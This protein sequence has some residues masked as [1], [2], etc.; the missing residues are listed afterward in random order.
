MVQPPLIG[1]SFF[2]L[3][4]TQFVERFAGFR[5]Q[6]SKKVL[7]LQFNSSNLV[8]A[9]ARFSDGEATFS[10][11]N[12]I[13]LPE[14]AVERGVPSD[15]AKMGSFIKSLCRQENIH[16]NRTAVVLPNE[17]VFTKLLDL[18]SDLTLEDTREYVANPLSGLQ[19]P[20]PLRHSDF[21]IS[22]VSLPHRSTDAAESNSYFLIS[23]PDKLVDQ[24]IQTLN[25]AGLE[26]QSVDLSFNCQ[27]RLFSADIA[28]LELG[29]FMVL[30]ELTPDCTYFVI[31]SASGPVSVLRL[32]AIREFKEPDLDD[33]KSEAA[34]SESLSG[35][36]LTLAGEEYMPISELDLR[37][38]L[39]ELR[40]SMDSFVSRL[41]YASWKG[42]ALSGLN[43]AH[44]LIADLLHDSL[45]IPVQV[46]HP[47]GATGVGN[48][49]FRKL[50]VHQTLGALFGLGLRFLPHQSL[51][52][53]SLNQN[54]HSPSFP[55]NSPSDNYVDVMT[56]DEV[57]SSHGLM[58]HVFEALDQSTADQTIP[59]SPAYSP[60]SSSDK[61]LQTDQTGHRAELASL[62]TQAV[63][64]DEKALVKPDETESE[65]D[66]E[67]EWPSLRLGE[68]NAEANALVEP[69]E[70]ESEE[71]LEEEW[72]SL[73]LGE[74]NAEENALVEP[75]ETESEEDLEE[76]W[77]S[78][79]L[80][81]L[82]AEENVLVEPGEI[83]SEDDLEEEW[84]KA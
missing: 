81:E 55:T 16:C 15:P 1:T 50:F 69:D 8:L 37:V 29:E 53:C 33:D 12:K 35:E 60:S 40:Q 21:D 80:G 24:L 30:L 48:A 45:H 41:P 57:V 20:I 64:E 17:A 6:I 39:T 25:Y 49:S 4:L 51:I 56:T 65:E 36:A 34:L 31:T 54:P 75:D 62:E 11:I 9:Q 3:D 72:P 10:K 42:I 58:S 47:L 26:L 2:G 46:I 67:E 76:E 13:A 44:P 43:S 61:F 52:A 5:R 38:L 18:P 83:E 77:P 71:D 14:G 32:A 70:I 84:P 23:T 68:L 66:L 82:N 28:G 27:L 79:R 73:R 7:L 22:Q 78:L 59:S 63:G 19:I 74:L